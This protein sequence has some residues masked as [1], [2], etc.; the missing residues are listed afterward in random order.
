MQYYKH[1]F[2]V[3]FEPNFTEGELNPILRDRVTWKSTK[4]IPEALGSVLNKDGFTAPKFL[5]GNSDTLSSLILRSPSLEPVIKTENFARYYVTT[6]LK[7]T[8]PFETFEIAIAAET[9]ESMKKDNYGKLDRLCD[10]LQ[11]EYLI[12]ESTELYPKLD[13]RLLKN[14]SQSHPSTSGHYVMKFFGLGSQ[15]L[16]AQPCLNSLCDVYKGFATHCL[17]LCSFYDTALFGG[18][19]YADITKI[20]EFYNVEIYLPELKTSF[21]GNAQNKPLSKKLFVTSSNKENSLVVVDLLEK[22]LEALA[23][24]KK[25][26]MAIQS[27]M[28]GISGGKLF[29]IQKY[30]STAIEKLMIKFGC[31]IDVQSQSN[32][33][34]FY[35]CNSVLLKTAVREFSNNILS[36]VYEFTFQ[37]QDTS[38]DQAMVEFFM[39]QNVDIDVYHNS[40]KHEFQIIGAFFEP[41]LQKMVQ[42]PLFD[43]MHIRNIRFLFELL[44]EFQDFITGKKFGKLNKI[45]EES[46]ARVSLLFE[47]TTLV[48]LPKTKNDDLK[49]NGEQADETLFNITGTIYVEVQDESSL[50]TVIKGVHLMQMEVP[51]EKSI[52][53]PESFHKAIIGNGGKLIQ[54]IMRRHNVFI[55]FSNTHCY[56]QSNFSFIRFD[57]VLIRCPYKNRKTISDAENELFELETKILQNMEIPMSI[58]RRAEFN[59][60][61]DSAQSIKRDNKSLVLWKFDLCELESMMMVMNK[62][63]RGIPKIQDAIGKLE[64]KN[65]VYIQFPEYDEYSFATEATWAAS[66][67]NNTDDE[68][69][70]ILAD[71]KVGVIIKGKNV[72]QDVLEKLKD[73]Q[74][75]TNYLPKKCHFKLGAVEKLSESKFQS[76]KSLLF[77]EYGCNI[78]YLK[79]S[80][81]LTIYY[82]D[83][84]NLEFAKAYIQ[85]DLS[86]SLQK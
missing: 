31:F 4:D 59:E 1:A 75:A 47:Q 74:L 27:T 63:Q 34:I 20:S 64:E 72:G 7:V 65:D 79:D 12:T 19:L 16:I 28:Q 62:G 58:D 6:N 45:E 83:A 49:H 86:V 57:N 48:P 5:V 25:Y 56:P 9:L 21:V 51:F 8:D 73:D 46:N 35:S 84:K 2:D 78:K 82:Y 66:K 3:Y 11:L 54:S 42:T 52:F 13:S 81:S 15:L 50:D 40:E 60:K 85:Q 33:V 41:L 36:K 53:I 23:K 67:Q 18:P 29:F 61:R 10:S 77:Y 38:Q 69:D 55:Q 70:K 39:F 76:W 80:N 14:N 26:V 17:E 24:Q 68:P 37:C 43:Q 22:R 32:S 44:P 30:Y 71:E